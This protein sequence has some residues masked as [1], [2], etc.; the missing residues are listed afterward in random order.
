MVSF[1]SKKMRKII[2][3][4]SLAAYATRKHSPSLSRRWKNSFSVSVKGPRRGYPPEAPIS[5]FAE[6]A[7]AAEHRKEKDCSFLQ[8]PVHAEPLRCSSSH[9]GRQFINIVLPVSVDTVFQFLFTASKFQMDFIALRESFDVNLGEWTEDENTSEKTRSLSCQVQLNNPLGPKTAL[10][11]QNQVLDKASRPG[12]LYAVDCEVNTHGIPYGDSFFVHLHFCITRISASQSSLLLFGQVK[13]RKSIW[14]LIK[15][16]IEKNTYA[17]MEEHYAQLASELLRAT[18]A[19]M[20]GMTQVR[21][22]RTSEHEHEHDLNTNE[23]RDAQ[24]PESPLA[25]MPSYRRLSH[26]MISRKE[27]STYLSSPGLLKM[28]AILLTGILI[29]NVCL[30]YQ[31]RIVEDQAKLS[32]RPIVAFQ[33]ELVSGEK[34][35]SDAVLAEV[36]K[37]KETLHRQEI[38]QWKDIIAMATAILKKVFLFHDDQPLSGGKSDTSFILSFVTSLHL[39]IPMFSGGM[40]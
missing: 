11:K 33:D 40:G 27:R 4:P 15:N 34:M 20:D 31:L 13:Y 39:M 37:Y 14:G 6:D 17:G 1:S 5:D 2:S 28:I 22:R 16:F 32:S 35:S 23:T 12:Y 24:S 30:F 8:E 9:E 36:L 19:D 38:S 21:G 29:S 25:R 26:R 7:E 3:E 18:G 10:S